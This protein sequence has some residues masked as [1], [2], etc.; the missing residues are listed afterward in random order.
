MRDDAAILPPVSS[1]NAAG[2]VHAGD[3]LTM[4]RTV[5]LPVGPLEIV[6]RVRERV[7]TL[8]VIVLSGRPVVLVGRVPL[9]E[10]TPYT[11]PA[12]PED[13]RR[14]RRTGCEEA[15]WPQGYGLDA[16]GALLRRSPCRGGGSAQ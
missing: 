11:Q 1:A 6:A 12:T 4:A 16:D 14:E 3:S 2:A 10:Q 8:I 9:R 7:R 13:A 15:I 5:A